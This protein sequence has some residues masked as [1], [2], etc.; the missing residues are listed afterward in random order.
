MIYFA[1]ER[2]VQRKCHSVSF[3]P[4]PLLCF[5]LPQRQF[6]LTAFYHG[7]MHQHPGNTDLCN[8]LLSVHLPVF[9]STATTMTKNPSVIQVQ[10]NNHPIILHLKIF[11]CLLSFQGHTLAYGGSQARGRIGTTIAG[12]CQ[13][14]QQ[15]QIQAASAIYPTAHSNARSLTH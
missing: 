3:K 7:E 2:K 4:C 15:C 10:Y 9:I 6:F 5:S 8:S 11:F 13:S 14:H 12:L 1:T